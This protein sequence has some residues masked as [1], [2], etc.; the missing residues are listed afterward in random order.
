MLMIA[1]NFRVGAGCHAGPRWQITERPANPSERE[2]AAALPYT[3]IF[4]DN[5]YAH[6]ISPSDRNGLSSIFDNGF[7]EKR[8]ANEFRVG[9]DRRVRP[10]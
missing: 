4:I 7:T 10:W 3:E 8:Y 9:A 5:H 6:S 2:G 1:K